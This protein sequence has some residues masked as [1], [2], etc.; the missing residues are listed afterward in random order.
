MLLPT[1]PFGV[2]T[3]QRDIKLDLNMYPSTQMAVLNDLVEV[4]NRQGI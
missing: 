2:N 1:V 3:G 4:L